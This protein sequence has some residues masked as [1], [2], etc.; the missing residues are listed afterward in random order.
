MVRSWA[1]AGGTWPGGQRRG[2]ESLRRSNAPAGGGRPG[3]RGESGP[4]RVAPRLVSWRSVVSGKN[5]WINREND[6]W[7]TGENAA[8]RSDRTPARAGGGETDRG[9]RTSKSGTANGG[10][11]HAAQGRRAQGSD[12]VRNSPANLRAQRV[13]CRSVAAWPREPGES[14]CPADMQ[15][16][17]QENT[18]RLPALMS[19]ISKPDPFSTSAPE[20]PNPDT[21]WN[22]VLGD[23]GWKE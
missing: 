23:P 7:A 6:Q 2:P 19:E 22:S 4:G 9:S 15:P 10:V 11:G 8:R 20:Y 18:D 3:G 13:D 14:L 5:A 1:G 17:A 16:K 12:R 21:L